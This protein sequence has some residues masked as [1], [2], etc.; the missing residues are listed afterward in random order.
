MIGVVSVVA[1][2]LSTAAIA[3][4][5]QF[6][7]PAEA[8]AML[9]KAVAAVKA[10]KTKAL[11]MFNTGEGGFKDRDLYVFCFNSG[12]GILTAGAAALIGKDV[13]TFKDASGDAFGQRVYDT[14]KEGTITEVSYMFPRPGSTEPAQ[15][16]SYVSNIGDQT[17][18]VGYYK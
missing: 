3:Q 16:S 1:L 14:A 5:G 17:C 7:T 6:G 18:G 8:K 10:D 15:K 2:T 12:D 13:R 9:E 11:A 4:Q